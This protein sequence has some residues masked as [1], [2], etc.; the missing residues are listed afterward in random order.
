MAIAG[1]GRRRADRRA[2]GDHHRPAPPPP[3]HTSSWPWPQRVLTASG[4]VAEY[5][6]VFTVRR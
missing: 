5:D 4:V 2:D 6:F 3:E 1:L